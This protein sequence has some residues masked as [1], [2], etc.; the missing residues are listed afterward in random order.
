MEE[1]KEPSQSF[2]ARSRGEVIALRLSADRLESIQP[3]CNSAIGRRKPL[4]LVTG[5]ITLTDFLRDTVHDEDAKLT[6][7]QR[8]FLALDVA[9][10]VLQLRQTLWCSTAD[11]WTKTS[12][13][14]LVQG[15]QCGVLC[16]P[17]VEKHIHK[18]QR[19]SILDHDMLETL[20]NL[21]ILLLEIWHH[22]SFETWTAAA[23]IEAIQ[24]STLHP[25]TTGVPTPAT[26]PD[27]VP[28]PITSVGDRTVAASTWL[29][30]TYTRLPVHHV[31]AVEK[32]LGFCYGRPWK[33]EDVQ[34]QQRSCE[35]I[36]KPLQES[37]KGW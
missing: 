35:D 5:A 26:T 24:N 3:A 15:G 22:T 19:P 34:F 7:K 31:E 29:R 16:T 1:D 13:K 23:A 11:A 20:L 8:T 18:N 21:A 6:P 9:S 27:P 30:R 37:C 10:S 33:W 17:F 25:P 4:P 14:F 12:V 2:Q 28:S 32:C 36:I